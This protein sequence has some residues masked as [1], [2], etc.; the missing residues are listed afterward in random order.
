MG[1]EMYGAE[2]VS[3][4]DPGLNLTPITEYDR[5]PLSSGF[6]AE[7]ISGQFTTL[8]ERKFSYFKH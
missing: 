2:S 6:S 5:A 3:P 4:K 8:S 7:L 1:P